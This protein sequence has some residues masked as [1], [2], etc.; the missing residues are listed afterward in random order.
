[1]FYTMSAFIA[2]VG[3]KAVSLGKANV[4]RCIKDYNYL[5][6]TA[7]FTKIKGEICRTINA[8]PSSSNNG[9]TTTFVA[10]K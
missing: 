9:L 4:L 3:S 5:Q 8:V 2:R 6:I 1:M 7:I 10:L